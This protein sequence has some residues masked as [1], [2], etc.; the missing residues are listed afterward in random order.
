MSELT[1]YNFHPQKLKSIIDET[2]KDENL[3]ALKEMVFEGWPDK[4]KQVPVPIR[5]Y[6]AFRDELA[7]EDGILLKGDCIIIPTSMQ[8][9]IL[10]K[11]HDAHQGIE[12][13]KLRAKSCVF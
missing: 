8:Q 9:D 12:K 11:L 3:Q 5:P 2:N 13:T 7:I 10:K 6:W 4:Q 1:W